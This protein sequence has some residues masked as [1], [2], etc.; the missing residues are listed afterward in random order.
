MNRTSDKSIDDIV[1]DINKYYTNIYLEYKP[2]HIDKKAYAIMKKDVK[3]YYN[4]FDQWSETYGMCTYIQSANAF[5]NIRRSNYPEFFTYKPKTGWKSDTA[6]WFTRN[7]KR[8]GLAKRLAIME[9]LSH[10][11]CKND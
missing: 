8:G 3:M 11:K 1:Y 6:Y 7:V 10:G 9:R 5:Y 4:T 2:S